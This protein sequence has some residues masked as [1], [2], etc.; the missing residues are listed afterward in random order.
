MKIIIAPSKT[1]KY[2]DDGFI[3]KPLLYQEKTEYLLSLLK[4]YN[5]EELCQL[6]KIS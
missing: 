2:R 4:Q 5:D 3:K 1:M 6:M